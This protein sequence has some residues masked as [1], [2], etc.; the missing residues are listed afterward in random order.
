MIYVIRVLCLVFAL[1][2]AGTATAQDVDAL[3]VKVREKLNKVNDYTAN[4]TLKTDVDFIKA[5]PGSI[6]VYYKKPD[7]LKMVRNGGISIL[8]KG[9]VGINMNSIITADKFSAIDAGE[10]TVNQVKTK[11]VKLLPTD[12]N[13]KVVLSTLYIEEKTLLIHKAVTTTVDNGTY[14]LTMTYGKYAAYGLPD[15]VVF[16]FNAKDYK[17]PKGIT[18]DFNQPSKPA[19]G[20]EKNKKGKVEISY[21]SYAINKGISDDVFK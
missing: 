5:P 7:R 9:G 14:E 15:K 17:L 6:T 12:E 11:I 18:L 10:G 13:S 20:E 8:P 2:L 4:G 1:Q 3:L 19:A 21:T 16:S